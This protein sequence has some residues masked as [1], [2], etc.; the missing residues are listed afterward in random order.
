[1]SDRDTVEGIALLNT[2]TATTNTMETLN[3]SDVLPN[4]DNR[5]IR[6]SN[7]NFININHGSGSRR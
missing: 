2:T 7:S 4:I 1:M 3:K 5:N 6:F